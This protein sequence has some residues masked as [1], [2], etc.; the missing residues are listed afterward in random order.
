MSGAVLLQE[1]LGLS[2]SAWGDRVAVEDQRGSIRYDELDSLSDRMRDRLAERGCGPGDRVGIYL[3][4][5]IDS[6]AAM[7]GILKAG[8][9]YVPVDPF[10]PPARNAYILSD[11]SVRAV[12]IES[13]FVEGLRRHW[14]TEGSVEGSRC[15]EL[16]I[17]SRAHRGGPRLEIGPLLLIPLRTFSIRRAPRANLRV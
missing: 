15:T 8:A 16:W 14:S 12:V 10:G 2:A 17:R 5:S 6:V 7:F 4:K 3:R 13:S 1:L 11:C 9:A